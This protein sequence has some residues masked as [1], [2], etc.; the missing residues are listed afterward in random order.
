M[1]QVKKAW[2]AEQELNKKQEGHERQPYDYN[3][4]YNLWDNDDAK[5]PQR[6]I[7]LDEWADTH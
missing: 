1:G 3:D 4:I 6:V 2:Q 5:E 7:D